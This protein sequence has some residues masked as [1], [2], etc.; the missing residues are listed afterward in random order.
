MDEVISDSE[1]RGLVPRQTI[2]DLSNDFFLNQSLGLEDTKL[3]DHELGQR[4]E[5]G[6]QENIKQYYQD[7]G[8]REEVTKLIQE[9]RKK[10]IEDLDDRILD[11]I[12][13]RSSEEGDPEGIH[14]VTGTLPNFNRLFDRANFECTLAS[15]MLKLALNDAGFRDARTALIT[16][17]QLVVRKLADGSIKYL[18]SA[19]RVTG[20]DRVMHG[21]SHTFS[22][23]QVEY[24]DN[25]GDTDH[26]A[27][28][29]RITVPEDSPSLSGPLQ[30]ILDHSGNT[31]SKNVYVNSADLLINLS[32]ALGNLSEVSKKAQHGDLKATA[33]VEQYPVLKSF[34][35]KQIES[36]LGLFNSQEY[37]AS[38]GK[39]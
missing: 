6:F 13:S 21:F 9:S 24:L 1:T 11:L 28:S 35:K 8:T 34:D 22:S 10:P 31:F 5:S 33:F 39:T 16:G 36:E 20:A 19:T 38:L 29:F 7:S 30:E 27:Y 18:D 32:T 37:L 26:S 15:A 25:F 23:D 12:M 4:V 3:S 2:I 17:H 14:G